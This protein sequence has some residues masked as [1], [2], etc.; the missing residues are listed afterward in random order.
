MLAANLAARQADER[1]ERA[2]LGELRKG[3]GK[4]MLG[5]G[6]PS[7][8]NAI[9]SFSTCAGRPI[10]PSS[11]IAR[12]IVSTSGTGVSWRSS[13]PFRTMSRVEVSGRPRP[14]A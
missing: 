5:R 6:M 2:G 12:R 11:T 13:A 7:G 14:A 4:A 10:M 1:L 9:W 3:T 8:Q